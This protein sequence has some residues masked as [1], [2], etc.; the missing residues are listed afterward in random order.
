MKPCASLDRGALV[1]N[2]ARLGVGYDGS[3]CSECNSSLDWDSFKGMKKKGQM[4]VNE[5]Y[6]LPKYQ[7]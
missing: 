4:D 5:L 6:T 1:L 7:K 3:V 2:L